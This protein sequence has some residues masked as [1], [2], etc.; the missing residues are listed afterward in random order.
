MTATTSPRA[1]KAPRGVRLEVSRDLDAELP[2]LWRV[3]DAARRADG[4]LERSTLEGF[5]A[6]YRHLEHCDP[7]TDIVLAWRGSDVVGYA[8]VEWNDTTDGERWYECVGMVHPAA[9]RQG[10]GARLL[11]WGEG[12]LREIITSHEARGI[13]LDRP[14][15]IVTNN[16]DRDLGGEVLLRSNGYAPF[17][18]FHSMR[19][20]TLADV[21]DVPLPDGFG[22]RPIPFERGPIERVVA[23][24]TEAF[25]DHFGALDDVASV[26]DQMMGNPRTDTSLWVIAVDADEIA[27]GVL[28]AIRDGHDGAAIGWLDSIFTR[29]PWRRRGL[30]RALIAR[31]LAILRDRGVAIAALGVDV[32]NPNQ[33]LRLYESCGFE[34][35]SSSTAYRKPVSAL[36]TPEA[37]AGTARSSR[38]SVAVR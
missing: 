10:I 8:R 13:A 2:L 5:S 33:A 30:A 3:G 32:S 16:H 20:S 7:E 26:V 29:R 28:N 12:R 22:I 4:E 6:Y 21:A 27:G 19:R 14:R 24:D 17:R 36:W 34:V 35:A 38:T 31:S 11:A 15:W 18:R 23:A 9:R 1:A 37:M 25:R